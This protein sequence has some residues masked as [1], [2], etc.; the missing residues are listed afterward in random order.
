MW[1]SSTQCGHDGESWQSQSFWFN[2][3]HPLRLYLMF[4]MEH[5]DWVRSK[6]NFL[7]GPW[8]PLLATVKKWKLTRFGHVMC[9]NSRPKTILQGTMEGGWYHGQQRKCC[10][11]VK[12]RT[13]LPT[14]EL[15][16]TASHKKT[17][18]EDLCW[19]VPHI[20]LKTWL[21]KVLN[22]MVLVPSSSPLKQTGAS[23]MRGK[24]IPSSQY[25]TRELPWIPIVQCM[26]LC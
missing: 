5:N 23:S 10:M 22:W 16:K 14:P 17:L 20:S 19:G 8:E 6:I 2:P 18:E 4:L 24:G 21:L 11:D 26:W 7:V 12:E 13:F 15:F 3:C 9:H 25:P 1:Y